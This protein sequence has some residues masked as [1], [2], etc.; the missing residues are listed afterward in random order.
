VGW[1]CVG[2]SANGGWIASE[3]RIG[4]VGLRGSA[5][6]GWTFRLMIRGRRTTPSGSNS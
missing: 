2:D 6:D 4:K 3:K 5:G 1:A